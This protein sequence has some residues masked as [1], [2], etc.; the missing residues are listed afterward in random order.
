MKKSIYTLLPFLLIVMLLQSGQSQVLPANQAVDSSN[1]IHEKSFFE[2]QKEFYDYWGPKQVKDGYYIENGIKQKAS[3]WK[4]FKR[5]EWYWE[6]RIDPQTG[7]FPDVNRAEIYKELKE[8]GGERNVSGN[9]QSL[10]PNSSPGGYAGLGRLNCVGFRTGDNLTYYAGAPSGGLWKTTDDGVNWT[11]LTDYNTVLGV[12]DVVVIAG[13]STATDVVYIATG[14]RDGGS[15]WSLGGGTFNDNNTIGV[16][17]STDGGSTWSATAL[18]YLASANKTTN[19]ILK[20]PTSDATLYAATTDGVFKT[21]NG[22]SSWPQIY[23]GNEFISMEFKPGDPTVM[24]GGTRSGQI[25]K[26]TNSGASWSAVLSVSGGLRVQLAVSA[27]NAAYVYAVVAKADGKLEGIYKSTDSGANFTKVY[28][29][30]GAGHYLLGYYC[31]GSVDGGQGTYDLCLAAD[32]NNAAILYLGGINTWK[33]TNSG[34]GWSPSNMWTSSSTY[35]P[36]GSPVAHADKH[37]LAFQNGSST[38]FECNDGGLYRTTNG[39]TSWTHLSNDMIISQMYRLGVSQTSSSSV[40]AGLQDNGTKSKLSGVWTDVIGGDGMECAIDPTNVNTQYGE[41]NG[42]GMYRTTN[43][44]ASSTSIVTGLTGTAYWVTPYVLDPTTPTTMYVGYSDVW[45]SINQGTNWTKISSWAGGTIRSIAVAPSN[46]NYIYAATQ[47][48]LYKTTIGGTTWNNITSGLPVG[49]SYITYVAVKNNDPLTVWVTF[50]Q[51]NSDRVYQTTNGG[52]TWTNIS[53]GLP[54]IPVM[55]VVQNTQNTSVIELYAGTDV[56][57]YVKV[58]TADW[59]L[60]STGL[61][62]VVVTELEIYYNTA[63]PHLS[64]LRAA[65]YGRGMWESELYAPSTALPVADFVADNT[66]PG[67]YHTVNMSDQTVND[68]TSWAWTINPSNVEYKNGTSASSQNPQIR[69][70]T[71]GAY[72]V[73]LYTANANGNSTETKT[74]YINVGDAP[75]SYCTGNSS[76]PYGYISRVQFGTI[77]KSSTYTNTGGFYYE[78]WTAF[79]TNV[80]VGQSYNIIVTN[81]YNDIGIDLGIWIDW[82]RDGDFSD[83]DENVLCSINNYGEGTFSINIPS[84]AE[85]GKT[86]MRLRSNYIETYCPPCGTYLNGEVEDYSVNIQPASTTWNGTTTNWTDASN[87]PNGIVPG[88]SYIVTIPSVPANG[89][90]PVIQQNTAAKCYSFTLQN[91]ATISVLGTLEVER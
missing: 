36:C 82:N 54:N 48:I 31:D 41:L 58:G 6:S 66:T 10:G 9:W 32:P 91:G 35:N 38:L 15:M 17:K 7:A 63:V 69:F 50:G 51:Y 74:S 18:T 26:S 70:K 78:N 60:Y 64:R 1:G 39:G 14:D 76:N 46:S 57:V 8:S 56:G 85:V 29:G 25:F 65:T 59:A 28:N 21:T 20:H 49:S 13:A 44:W 79:S 71:T 67:V 62:N 81:P 47:S 40:I 23:S 22:G 4:L 87:W 72:N 12:S 53:A 5:W 83:L 90:F 19:R 88:S 86:R 37:L 45:K 75:G 68:P 89:N 84:H 30:T 61:P 33:S 42:G 77:D 52:T 3:G 27:N 73:S 11:P 16:L 2:I 55:C 80:T 43:A 34:S 24:Y